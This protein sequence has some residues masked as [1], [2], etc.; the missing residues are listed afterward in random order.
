[1]IVPAADSTVDEVLEFAARL[2]EDL[3]FSDIGGIM[4]KRKRD[5]ED[6]QLRL[7]TIER[8]RK[9][10]ARHIRAFKSRTDLDALRTLS[11]LPAG[12][13]HVMHL[14]DAWP[15]AWKGLLHINCTIRC[16]DNCIPPQTSYQ[17]EIRKKGRELLAEAHPTEA[18]IA[19][20]DPPGEII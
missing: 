2:I 18:R 19:K 4:A 6:A 10:C 20:D 3:S 13:D 8:N 14:R 7:E 16:S 5:R 11:E 9:D 1:M 12:T 15:L 17:I